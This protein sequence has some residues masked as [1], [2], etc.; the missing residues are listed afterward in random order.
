MG[1]QVNPRALELGHQ[2]IDQGDYRFSGN[3]ATTRPSPGDAQAYLDTHGEEAYSH[4]YLALNPDASDPL[5][6]Y[7]FAIGDFAHLHHTGLRDARERAA[8]TGAADVVDAA[9]ELLDLL[10]R[11]NAC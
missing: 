4:W 11:L 9:D 3:W 2:L 10:D 1:L 5:D 6:R 8:V 7:Q